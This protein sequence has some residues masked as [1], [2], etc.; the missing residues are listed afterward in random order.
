M[1]HFALVGLFTALFATQLDGQTPSA[2]PVLF[3]VTFN[4]ENSRVT[5]AGNNLSGPLPSTGYTPEQISDAQTR[6]SLDGI[7]LI[8]FFQALPPPGTVTV[9]T[10]S[11]Q[12]TVGAASAAIG[13]DNVTPDLPGN[14]STIAVTG[15]QLILYAPDDALVFGTNN[16]SFSGSL[17]LIAGTLSPTT[18]TFSESL[19]W[20]QSFNSQNNLIG[21][22]L[23]LAG[24]NDA[25]GG[26][27]ILG[28]Y[29]ISVVPEPSTYAAIAG[30]LGLAAAVIHR[31]RQRAKAAQA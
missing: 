5:I 18:V 14:L 2:L 25:A 19:L 3:Q 6:T 4:P 24:V 17:N 15:R 13:L 8:N 22:L 21:D 16:V 12:I 28:T 26:A 30:G 29:T 10:N 31:R 9:D 7:T 23:V 27:A 1:K 20:Y 11:L